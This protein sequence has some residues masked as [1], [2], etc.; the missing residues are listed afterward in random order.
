M[1]KAMNMQKLEVDADFWVDCLM[2]DCLPC[3]KL[4]VQYGLFSMR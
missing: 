1:T 2:I 4:S 3:I